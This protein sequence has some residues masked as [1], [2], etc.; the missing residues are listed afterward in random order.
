MTANPEEHNST[1]ELADMGGCCLGDPIADRREQAT[2]IVKVIS[3]EN[4]E[5]GVAGFASSGRLDQSIGIG[6]R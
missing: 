1:V 4:P 5:V 2:I 3:N 6:S